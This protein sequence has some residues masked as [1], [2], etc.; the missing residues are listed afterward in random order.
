MIDGSGASPALPAG[1]MRVRVIVPYSVD[2]I[3]ASPAGTVLTVSE[4][5]GW[6]LIRSGM[7]VGVKSSRRETAHRKP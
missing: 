4:A 1:F 6:R 7:A 5:E 3:T 2:G